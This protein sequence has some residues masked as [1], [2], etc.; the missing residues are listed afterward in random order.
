MAVFKLEAH[1]LSVRVRRL[2]TQTFTM[3]TNG[4]QNLRVRVN[5]YQHPGRVQLSRAEAHEEY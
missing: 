2:G 3:P 4:V 1:Q 5:L